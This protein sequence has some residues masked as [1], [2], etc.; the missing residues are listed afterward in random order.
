[1]S[2]HYDILR[3]TQ[4]G[5]HGTNFAEVGTD[6]I[7]RQQAI[8]AVLKCYDN[9]EMFEVYEDKLRALPAQPEAKRGKWL[10]DNNNYI[11]EQCIHLKHQ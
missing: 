2:D 3:D 8:D 7:S 10:P 6:S 1:M 4:Y 5:I 11:Y 9:D